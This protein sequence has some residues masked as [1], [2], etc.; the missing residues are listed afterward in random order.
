MVSKKTIVIIIGV[1]IAA[2]IALIVFSLIP[3]A[4]LLL[5]VAPEEFTIT[6]DGKSRSAKINDKITI[7]PGELEVSISRDKFETYTKKISVK[8]GETYEILEA[9][10]PINSEDKDLLYT[11]KTAGVMQR[12]NDRE[13]KQYTADIEAAYPIIKILPIREKYFFV[14]PCPSKKFPGD[15][16]KQALCIQYSWEDY[17][18]YIPDQIKKMGYDLKDYEVYYTYSGYDSH[19]GD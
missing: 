8:N 16:K 4:T 15:S 17:K 11:E 19:H 6:I 1:F 13:M 12:I 9:L 3:R 18:S 10:K 2:I 14:N 5:S 7:T